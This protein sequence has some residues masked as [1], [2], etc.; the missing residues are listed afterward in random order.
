MARLKFRNEFRVGGWEFEIAQLLAG[1]PAK[2]L[3]VDRFCLAGDQATF[4]KAKPDRFFRIRVCQ[5]LDERADK[6][7]DFK[8]LTNFP[9]E[10]RFERFTGFNLA[11]GKLPEIWKMIVRPPLRNQQP[12][13]VKNQ[14][15]SD[16]NRFQSTTNGFVDE[17]EAFHFFG[18]EE[19]AAVEHDGVGHRFAR[20]FEV[21]L[22]ELGPFGR[23]NDR[24][25]T[26]GR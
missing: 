3:N 26:F 8:L 22:F 18:V 23:H 19:V 1:D 12:A 16:I 2:V 5:V 9:D 25:A 21:E 15:S 17:P 6:D 13:I 14:R 20:A 11:A 10:T 4:E 7:F 24:V